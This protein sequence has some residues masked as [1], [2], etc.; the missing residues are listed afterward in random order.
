[1]TATYTPI[2]PTPDDPAIFPALSGQGFPSKTPIWSTAI[3]TATSGRERRSEHWSYP[4]WMIKLAYEVVL[5]RPTL[6]ELNRLLG[7]F[8]LYRGRSRAFSFYDPNDN[9]VTNQQFGTGDGVTKTFQLLRTG[10][11]G[12]MK[13]SEPVLAVLG[14]PKVSVGISDVTAFTIGS[15][16]QITFTTAPTSGAA[17]TWSGQFMFRVR[18]DQ[19]EL[20]ATQLM[21][22]LWSQ[23]GLTLISDKR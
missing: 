21:A 22:T 3:A 4:K 13:W 16:G 23:N 20:E 14:T 6:D 12:Q 1:L 9:L 17:L 18:F 7:F 11:F 2:A 8:N 5:Q 19:D 15:L 10:G